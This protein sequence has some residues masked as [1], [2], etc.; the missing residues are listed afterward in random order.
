VSGNYLLTVALA[1]V[2]SLPESIEYGPLT[3][4]IPVKLKHRDKPLLH[5]DQRVEADDRLFKFREKFQ[6]GT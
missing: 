6:I 3:L 2:A 5:I 1:Q 4:T